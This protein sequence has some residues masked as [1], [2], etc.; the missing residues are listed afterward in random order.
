MWDNGHVFFDNFEEPLCQWKPLIW[1]LISNIKRIYLPQ[2][3]VLSFH[4]YMKNSTINVS[5]AKYFPCCVWD[6][7]LLIYLHLVQLV[8]SRQT[9]I[10]KTLGQTNSS[11]FNCQIFFKQLPLSQGLFKVTKLLTIVSCA[12]N[13][14]LA[15]NWEFIYPLEN[16]ISCRQGVILEVNLYHISIHNSTQT[17]CY[18]NFSKALRITFIKLKPAI[19]RNLVLR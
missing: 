17:G 4:S 3:F 7:Y 16:F 15:T 13:F 12:K 14:L 10:T 8:T 2:C 11:N 1:N 6:T 19:L 5:N 9:I 18:S